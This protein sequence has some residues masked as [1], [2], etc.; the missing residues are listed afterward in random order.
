MRGAVAWEAGAPFRVHDDLER[1]D[2]GP[3]E[4]VVRIRAAGVC[5]TDISLARGA[6]ISKKAIA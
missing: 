3:G 6:N 2:P 4:V 5:Q 1:R